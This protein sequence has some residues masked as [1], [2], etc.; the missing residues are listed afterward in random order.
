MMLPD[1]LTKPILGAIVLCT[2]PHFAYVSPWV[3]AAC[4]AMWTYIAAASIYS[5]RL[6]GRMVIRILAG[7]F[8]VAAMST[9]EGFTIEAFV[10]LLSL[11]AVLKLLEIRTMRDR[12]VTVILCYFLIAGRLFFGDSIGATAYLLFSVLFTTAVLIHVNQPLPRAQA[13]TK[14]AALL[15]VQAVPF[16]LV[17]FLLFPR[18]QGG[19][20]GRS[21]LNL[22]RTGF[23]D[24]V[25]FGDIAEL[26]QNAAVAF[27][28]EFTGEPPPRNQ[29][30]WRGIVLWDFDGQTWRRGIGHYDRL[31]T[32]PELS[33][34]ITY[35]ITLEPH[36]QHWLFALDAPRE[37][38]LR[39]ARILKD[40]S[41]YRWRPVTS[42]ISYQA[43]SGAGVHRS[44]RGD[45]RTAA[46]QLPANGNP[47]ARNLAAGLLAQAGTDEEY[48]QLALDYFQEQPF[49]YTLKPP[50]LGGLPDQKADLVD[51]FLFE[52]R[53]GF[54]EHYASSFAFLM[55]AAGLPARIVTGYQGGEQNPFGGY[56]AVRQSDA[57]AWCEVWL[58]EKGW[59]RVDPTNAVAPARIEGNVNSAV[60]QIET[61]GMLSFL[62]TGALGE[63]FRDATNVLDFYNTRWNQWVLS[64]SINEQASL[65]T[66]MGWDIRPGTELTSVLAVVLAVSVLAIIL[67]SSILFRQAAPTRDLTAEAWLEFCRKLNW[68]GLPREPGQGPQDYLEFVSNRRPD[69]AEPARKIVST[70]IRVRYGRK[71]D[72]DRIMSLRKMVKQFRPGKSPTESSAAV[73]TSPP[74]HG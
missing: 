18:F 23:S 12:M 48:I 54:C 32:P 28:V 3:T 36:N 10:A 57:H 11:M 20:W 69:L 29:L 17:F 62:I 50:A 24:Q 45:Y 43:I 19:L 39:W 22:A 16:M 9:H 31:Y 42:R 70:Y 35:T 47:R 55:R 4:L 33:G 63:W 72:A 40:Q 34:D 44:L 68:S 38:S 73:N 67:I 58:E 2:L 8:L 46:L 14:L 13:H 59:I 7:I 6:P 27:R 41:V 25:S 60:P 52:S 5:W 61:A 26:A 51:R 15:V 37:V 21:H 71:D 30:Y 66:H 65:F 64:Y 1:R 53:K 56:L 49:S 74:S